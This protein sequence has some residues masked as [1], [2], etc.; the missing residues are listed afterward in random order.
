MKGL[1]GIPSDAQE[2][3]QYLTDAGSAWEAIEAGETPTMPKNYH[4]ARGLIEALEYIKIVQAKPYTGEEK[5]IQ[6]KKVDEYIE[7]LKRVQ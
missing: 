5:E 4:D 1:E 2:R 6:Y 7:Q 3:A